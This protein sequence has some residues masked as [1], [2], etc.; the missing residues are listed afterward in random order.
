MIDV[1]NRVMSNIKTAEEGVCS[2]ISSTETD[3]P[4]KFPA[5]YVTQTNAQDAAVDLENSENGVT[6]EIRIQAF[7]KDSLAEARKVI[8]I[9]CEAMR[10]MGYRRT[11]GPRELENVSDRNVKRTEA[12]FRRFVGSLEDIPKFETEAAPDETQPEP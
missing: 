12:R 10:T 5:M 7:S 3:Y 4:P 2:F 9:A 1:W 8:W 11:L 6:S